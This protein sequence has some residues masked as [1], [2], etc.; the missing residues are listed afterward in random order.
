MLF[1]SGNVPAAVKWLEKRSSERWP[2]DKVQIESKHIVELEAG[3]YLQNIQI[4]MARLEERRALSSGE[5]VIDVEAEE[6]NL[7]DP[8]EV[9]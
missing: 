3:E 1:R 7:S 4:L 8:Q 5:P 6:P 9:D 2:S